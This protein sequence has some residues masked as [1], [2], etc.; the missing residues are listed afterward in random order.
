LDEWTEILDNG[1]SIDI[2]YTDFKKA[3]NTVPHRRLLSKL[4]THGVKGKVLQWIASFLSNRRQRVV[5]NGAKSSEATV[6][7]SILQGSVFE[8]L[9]FVVFINDLP[10]CVSA[11]VKMFANDTKVYTRIDRESASEGLQ[12]HINSLQ[13]W[14]S[15]WL[16]KFHPQKCCVMKMGA[17][18][19]EAEYQMSAN[20]PDG[21]AQ[22]V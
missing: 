16:L 5:V 8:S 3:F 20:G 2:I 14:S 1:G 13:Q 21:T 12:S 17:K 15:D 19:S 7:S 22:A 9:L 4:S 18:K 6:C 10:D 11:S